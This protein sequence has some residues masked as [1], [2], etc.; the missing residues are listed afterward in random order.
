MSSENKLLATHGGPGWV[1]R[2]ASVR[3]EMGDIWQPCGSNSEFAR[4]RQILLSRPSQRFRNPRGDANQ[5]LL[6]QWPDWNLLNEQYAN[7]AS[8]YKD[9][10]V[11]AHT[12]DEEN[13]P[14]NYLF[15]RD[16]FFMTPHGA[17]LGRPASRQRA[18]EERLVFNK[19]ATLGVPICGAMTGTAC[20]EGADA[21]WLTK[22]DLALGIGVRTNREAELRVRQ[23]LPGINLHRFEMPRGVQHLLGIVLIV[24][25]H[26]A[27]IDAL[28]CP[29]AI[30]KLLRDFGFELIALDN[31]EELHDKR[32]MNA[33]VLSPRRLVMPAKC[34]KIRA[35]LES[36]G[37]EVLTQQVSEY[38]KAAGALGCMTAIIERDLIV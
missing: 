16:L 10:G 3:Q 25:K 6:R 27:V 38:I 18:G 15:M 21:L 12:H 23:L 31:A 28:R 30:C 32:G 2:K 1:A 35:R 22:N 14:V 33:V 26:L 36:A 5:A 8:F 17:I 37:I 24:D 11:T 19:L 13:S 20:L 4:L 29:S 7:I 34:P 9:C